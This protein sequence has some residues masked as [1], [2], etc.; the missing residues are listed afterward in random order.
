MPRFVILEHDSPELHWDFMLQSGDVLR[1][2]R[3]EKAPGQAGEEI[4]ARRIADH[5]PFYL[6]Y[7]GPVS[8][9]RGIVRRWDSG[10]YEEGTAPPGGAAIL[11]HLEGSRLRGEAIL[12]KRAGEEWLFRFSR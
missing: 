10:W 9:D 2:W 12:E 7:E 3:L 6:D 1:T 11:L 5:R 4:A 8:G